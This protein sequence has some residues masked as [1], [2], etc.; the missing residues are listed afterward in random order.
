MTCILNYMFKGMLVSI[1][2]RYH[3]IVTVKDPRRVNFPTKTFCLHPILSLD[4]Q[5]Y[6]YATRF[7]IHCL[8]GES[9]GGISL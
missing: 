8:T 2:C 5:E 1:L 9:V 3:F 4:P 6:S 7:F